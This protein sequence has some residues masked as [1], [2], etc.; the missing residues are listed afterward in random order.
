MAPAAESERGQAM[1]KPLG[2]WSALSANAWQRMPRFAPPVLDCDGVSIRLIAMLIAPNVKCL[3]RLT[4][5]S[6][7]R[8][9]GKHMDQTSY[10]RP[11]CSSLEWH[12]TQS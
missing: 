3:A 4:S 6:Y 9:Y 11:A 10:Y 12:A 8:H 2:P 5:G 1:G 7:P